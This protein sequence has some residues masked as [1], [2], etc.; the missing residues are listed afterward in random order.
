MTWP[1]PQ[2]FSEAVQNPQFTFDDGDLRAGTIDVTPLGLPKVIS[3]QFACVFKIM[4]AGR[5]WAVRCFLRDFQ[6]QKAR[7][8]ALSTALTA[9][10]FDFTVP[11]RFIEKG[12]LVRGKWYPIIKM[13]WLK[14]RLLGDYIDQNQNSPN[15]L[16]DLANQ[17]ALI[18]QSLYKKGI[19]HGDL[20]HGN[21]I[22]VGN[23]V[24]L[25]DYDGMYVPTMKGMTSHEIG[26][27]N[28]QHPRRHI[29]DFSETTDYFSVWIIYVSL[30]ILAEDLSL[31]N[32]LGCGD[33]C[34]IFKA[35]DYQAPYLSKTFERLKQHKNDKI[36]NLTYLIEQLCYTDLVGIPKFEVPE[37]VR[38]ESS[39]HG[40]NSPKTIG[41]GN[42]GNWIYDWQSNPS[43]LAPRDD[44]MEWLSDHLPFENQQ[45]DPKPEW[46]VRL[47]LG[48]IAASPAV[49]P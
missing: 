1:T 17:I 3:G 2:D 5:T 25:I 44:P 21:A 37:F 33:D 31:W 12:I 15:V 10:A 7:Y 11:F 27:K 26:H 32:Y 6:D 23:K 13:E 42:L 36:K 29:D 4:N 40:A 24:H 30:N 43:Q 16:R 28:Y 34:I 22:V 41:V 45:F 14:G 8:D 47:A 39:C 48:L 20:Q 9:C 35:A 49:Y 19:S 18:H 46:S 38:L